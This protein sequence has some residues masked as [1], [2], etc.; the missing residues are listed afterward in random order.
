[1]LREEHTY[2]LGVRLSADEARERDVLVV[3]VVIR[4]VP[5]VLPGLVGEFVELPASKICM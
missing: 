4:G 1:M 3:R 2:G 5:R